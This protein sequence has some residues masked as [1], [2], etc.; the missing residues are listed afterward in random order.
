M[1]TS[2]GSD[3]FRYNPAHVESEISGNVTL[4]TVGELVALGPTYIFAGAI[5]HSA[6]TADLLMPNDS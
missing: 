5:T 1:S 4:D 3:R 6:A 2:R